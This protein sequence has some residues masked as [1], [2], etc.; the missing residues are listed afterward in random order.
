MNS[1]IFKKVSHSFDDSWNVIV[2]KNFIGVLSLNNKNTAAI[3]QNEL[4]ITSQRKE[5]KINETIILIKT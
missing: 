3:K 1:M 2:S 4:E 5:K